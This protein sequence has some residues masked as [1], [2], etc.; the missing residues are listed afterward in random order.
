MRERVFGALLLGIAA[1]PVSAHAFAQGQLGYLAVANPAIRTRNAVQTRDTGAR[2]VI[3]P[4]NAASNLVVNGGFE[5]GQAPWQES[6]SGGYQMIDYSNPHSGSYSAWLC[7]YSACNDRL[8]QT[9]G[10]PAIS[11]Q[12]TLQFY[13]FVRTR[14]PSG[15][16]CVDHFSVFVRTS[17]GASVTSPLTLCNTDASGSWSVHFY[18]LTSVLQPF[19]GQQVQLWFQ[20]TTSS[21]NSS[22]FFVDDVTFS[23]GTGSL[24]SPTTTS[25]A[26]PTSTPTSTAASATGSTELV[27]NGGFEAGQTPWHEQ[28]SGGYQMIDYS[29]PHT[30]SYSAWL[31]GLQ[32]CTERL[33][34][35]ISVPRSATSLSFGYWLYVRTNESGGCGDSVTSS[36]QSTSGATLLTGQNTCNNAAS[37]SWTHITIDATSLLRSVAGQQIQANFRATT[38][39]S[40]SSDFF[41]DDVSLSAGT[42]DPTP[43]ATATNTAL[44]TSTPTPTSTPAPTSTR[45]GTVTGT[46][47]TVTGTSTTSPTVT[48][49]GASETNLML[50]G[51]F[52][53]GQGAVA[54]SVE[55]RLPVHRL[56]SSAHGEL[57]GLAVRLQLVLRSAVADGHPAGG[58]LPG[59]AGILPLG[60]HAGSGP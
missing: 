48:P 10:L 7:G 31:C 26:V 2:A 37:G 17:S 55:R 36:I 27:V 33:W 30:G 20:A 18:D 57:L 47:P 6:S 59:N 42:S 12:L 19:A 29:N 23:A 14:E 5:A 58:R 56:Q 38:N 1:A 15:S 3:A 46:A 39:S 22:D 4:A 16:G 24:P 13:T 40:L 50:N 44:H 52:E 32:Q 53:Q 8:S 60:E 41:V 51:G 54:R 34:Q 45:T 21:S 25:P 9:V 49:T 35:V 28:S 43:T 11:A